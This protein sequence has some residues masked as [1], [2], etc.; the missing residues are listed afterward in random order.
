M[1]LRAALG[2]VPGSSTLLGLRVLARMLVALPALVATAVVL[3]RGPA[4]SPYFTE[5]SLPLPVDA[6]FRL[7]LAL[8]PVPGVLVLAAPLL[9]WPLQLFVT[10]GAIDRFARPRAQ[11]RSMIRVCGESLLL[12]LGPLLRVSLLGLLA[13]V[14]GAALLALLHG[15]VALWAARGGASRR[16]VLLLLPALFSGLLL[17]W[18]LLIGA[19]S[20][21]AK[22]LTVIDAR[23]KVRRTAVLA[24]RLL[25]DFP[26]RGLLFFAAASGGVL[27]LEAVVL[28][29]W[30]SLDPR[31]MVLLALMFAWAASVLL[32]T[33]VWH[34][35][36][37]AAVLVYG[38]S[39][40]RGSADLR[41]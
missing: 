22:V 1:T 15:E 4:L 17:S 23:R 41:D 20:L 6:L 39:P 32:S 11:R 13:L 2:P 3:S 5:A 31:G 37:R 36:V 18:S 12:H 21:A 7:L 28:L 38:E 27:A 34:W 30:R 10:A 25:L 19:W 16:T 24:L 29:G 35:T 40:L 8:G 14:I 26:G 9:A 33:F